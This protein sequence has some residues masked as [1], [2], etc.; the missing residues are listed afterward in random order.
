MTVLAA[1]MAYWGFADALNAAAVSLLSLCLV[2]ASLIFLLALPESR[3]LELESAD[4]EH[5]PA[6]PGA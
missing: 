1:L 5:T 4:A 3:G 2:A 6:S